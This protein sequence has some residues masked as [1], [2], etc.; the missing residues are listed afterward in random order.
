MYSNF[1]TPPDFVDE[2][3]HTVV[4][5][6]AASEDVQRLALLCKEGTTDFNIYL[7]NSESNSDEWLMSA[8]ER[9]DKIIVNTF[10][11]EKS[12]I[13]Q[14]LKPNPKAS[15]Y[16]TGETTVE[17]LQKYFIDYI[18]NERSHSTDSTL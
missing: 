9:A 3:K 7:Y 1:V 5:I 10:A 8:I 2:D 15:F 4:V 13:K 17:S 16:G 12:V 14:L 6:D 18:L 11:N